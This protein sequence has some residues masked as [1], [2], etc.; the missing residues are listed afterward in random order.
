MTMM[1][2][3]GKLNSPPERGTESFE[4]ELYATGFWKL[5]LRSVSAAAGMFSKDL[6]IYQGF[7]HFGNSL[8]FSSAHTWRFFNEDGRRCVFRRKPQLL[9]CSR[10]TD[11]APF[12]VAVCVAPVSLCLHEEMSWYFLFSYFSCYFR[13]SFQNTV[14]E[15]SLSP[16][17]SEKLH[18]LCF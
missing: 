14:Q 12:R 5:A 2:L 1:S 6:G 18:V 10:Y 17:T 13:Q 16:H 9:E 11:S 3:I 15:P 4:S 7:D 8:I